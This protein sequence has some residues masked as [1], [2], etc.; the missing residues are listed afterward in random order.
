MYQADAG[1]LKGTVVKAHG[2][3]QICSTASA[4]AFVNTYLL[5]CRYRRL[6]C[7]SSQL[8]EAQEHR[9]TH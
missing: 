1:V 8:E 9:N 6:S 7:F 4:A 5:V 2:H 3:F